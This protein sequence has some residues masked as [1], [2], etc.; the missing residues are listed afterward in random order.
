MLAL[1]FLLST[2][3]SQSKGGNKIAILPESNGGDTDLKRSRT[4]IIHFKKKNKSPAARGRRTVGFPPLVEVGED[5]RAVVVEALLLEVPAAGLRDRR[6]GSPRLHLREV[7]RQ[8]RRRR[9]PV[10]ALPT[11]GPRHA[12]RPLQPRGNGEEQRRGRG[13]E[14]GARPCH[15]RRCQRQA[16]AVL[17]G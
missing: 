6:G 1:L 2:T 11:E 14:E 12:P 13:R 8:E 5:P 3:D 4:Q 15:Q 10:D 9:G 7:P 16:E 17:H